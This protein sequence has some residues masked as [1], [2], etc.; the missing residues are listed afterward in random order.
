MNFPAIHEFPCYSF[1]LG[2]LHAHVVNIMFVLL[3]I[4]LLYVW[5]RGVRKKTVPVETS[6][7]DGKFWKEQLLMP[8]L[9]VISVL[10]GMF[11]WT[12]FWDFVIYYVV[13]LGT[14]LFA[15]IIVSRKNKENHGC[16]F[17]T[18]GRNLSA[19]L[20]CDPAIYLTV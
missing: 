2:D 16:N 7:K 12:N 18:N 3:V 19:C 15:N 13:T 1:V 14:V 6:M 20:S 5:L 8:H 17:C 9:L 10:L 11:Q 4:A